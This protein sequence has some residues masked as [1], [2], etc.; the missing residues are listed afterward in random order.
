M[1]SDLLAALESY[2]KKNRQRRVWRKVV[3]ILACFVVFCTT[4]ALILPAI[5]QET[6]LH[7]G[8]DEHTHSRDCQVSITKQLTCTEAS[9]NIHVH[10]E[11]CLDETGKQICGL[12]DYV[13][14][15]HDASCLDETETL[16]C[17]LPE[18][19]GHLHTEACYSTEPAHQHTESCW[20]AEKGELTCSLEEEPEAH[21]HTEACYGETL[22]CTVAENHVHSDSCRQETPAC[23]Q[24]E[25]ETHTHTEQCSGV[26]LTLVCTVPE[27]HL[28]DESCYEAGLI[29]GEPDPHVHGDGC[30]AWEQVLT[31][32]QTG[33]DPVQ[34]LSCTEPVVQ[35]HIHG[36]DCFTVSETA[37]TCDVPEHSHSLICHSDPTAD[38]ETEEVWKQSMAAV[39]LTGEWHRD[40][41]AIAQSQ[42]GYVESVKNYQ[43]CD[44]GIT[45]KGY[46]RYGQWYGDPY[47][48]WCVMFASFCLNYAHVEMPLACNTVHWAHTLSDERWEL[49]HKRADHV[50]QPGEVIFFD[51]DGDE[52]P[53]HVGIVAEVT[54]E[55]GCVPQITAIEGNANNR[56]MYTYYSA[57]NED[58]LGYASL[59]VQLTAQ[60][61]RAVE[62]VITRI[63]ALP[64][65]EKIQKA[66]D[67]GSDSYEDLAQQVAEAYFY[68]SQLADYQKKLVTNWDKLLTMEPVWSQTEYIYY[69]RINSDPVT[70]VPSANT[71]DF[72]ELNIFDY[73]GK[74]SANTSNQKD[75]NERFNTVSREFPG[76]RWSGGAYPYQYS[77]TETGWVADR[78]LHQ[79]VDFGSGLIT[80][81]RLTA[82]LYEPGEEGF[83]TE[84]SVGPAAGDGGINRNVS[85][86][87][88]I[89]ATE[90][91]PVVSHRLGDDGYPYL[92]A[93]SEALKDWDLS[94]GYLFDGD[95][96]DQ[97]ARK[98]NGKN[99][100]GLF[101]QDPVSGEYFYNSRWNH[102]QYNAEASAFTLYSQT[103]TPNF[104][105]YPYGSFLPFQDIT[106]AQSVTQVQAF[107][108]AGGIEDYFQ[109]I[110]DNLAVHN[111][112]AQ[113]EDLSVIQLI[114]MLESYRNSW[115]QSGDSV[116]WDQLTAADVLEDFQGISWAD[117]PELAEALKELY[118]IDYDAEKNFFFGMEMKLTFLQAENGL[119]GADRGS[120]ATGTW[121]WHSDKN[122]DTLTAHDDSLILTGQSDGIP[123]YPMV[124]SFTG[125]DDVWVYIDGIRF[126]DLSGIHQ[127]V[128]GKIDFEKGMVYYYQ[129]DPAGNGTVKEE[130][131]AQQSFREILTLYGGIGEEDLGT[132]LKQDASGNYTTF[133]D[134]SVHNLNLYYLERSADSS[135]YDLRFNL[136]L[137]RNRSITVTKEDASV[138]GETAEGT[139]LGNPDYYFNI[140]SSSNALFV[141]PGSVTGITQYRIQDRNGN[142]LKNEDGTD[143]YFTTDA[144]GIFTLKAGQTAIFEGIDPDH[145]EFFVQELIRAEDNGQYAAVYSNDRQTRDNAQIDWSSRSYFGLEDRSTPVYEGPYGY[146]WYGRSGQTTESS[147]ANAFAFKQH[148]Q[149]DAGKLGSL[150]ISQKLIGAETQ[151][152][153]RVEV[154]LD[155]EKLP[156]GTGYTVN[157]ETRTVE[158]AGILSLS[159]GET[160][161]VGNIL[162][163]TQFTVREVETQPYTVS[164]AYTGD[165]TGDGGLTQ[166]D[167]V[168]GVVRAESNPAI[169]V[170]SA[171]DGALVQIP[172]TSAP[173]N[174]DGQTYSYTFLLEQVTDSTGTTLVE[175]GTLL[176][177]MLEVGDDPAFFQ[178]SIPYLRTQF[179]ALP[180]TFYYRILVKN[181]ENHS[182]DNSQ[183]FVAQVLVEETEDG[184]A[185]TLLSINGEPE[186]RSA[187]FVNTLAGSLT[188]HIAVGGDEEH[189]AKTFDFELG[190]MLPENM[191]LPGELAAVRT[192]ADGTQTLLTLQP[193]NGKIKIE[194]LADGET[195]VITGI[196]TGT[197]WNLSESYVNG[198]IVTTQVGDVT[199]E[200]R[201]AAGTTVTGDTAVTYI[202]TQTYTLPATGGTGTS[203][204]TMAG[205]MLMLCSA[206]YLLYQF[207]KHRKGARA[208]P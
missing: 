203:L 135:A 15:V 148:S 102:A 2:T 165:E 13:V 194:D 152:A 3:Q 80:D 112:A 198:F 30:Y 116:S 97:Y 63:E 44:D 170:T 119:T 139:L 189:K 120:N 208:N 124:F 123:D 183:Q 17:T 125:E 85:G 204:Y 197:Q 100:D 60:E 122:G 99:V 19:T 176:E 27:G 113:G 65:L 66:K 174:G 169:T 144:Y 132:Y 181:G 45:Q 104:I 205:W 202:N 190:L 70:V 53:N 191:E 28:H 52:V 24:S 50:P 158:E 117:H 34:V 157:G 126:L 196:P 153:F 206:A 36:E 12:V 49:F 147:F 79:C 177:Q 166:N 154:T 78:H 178:F 175:N 69:Y 155:G 64:T 42:L 145:G 39:E 171:E 96:P 83:Q 160:A 5:T 121:Q 115:Q 133:L 72:V 149:V 41:V 137:V 201:Y 18:R 185:A 164:Y 207:T 103:V 184:M 88:P 68:Y 173:A 58:I 180:A 168:T 110:L 98:K 134:Y 16:V 156:V 167:S 162:S 111:T 151:R 8:F 108:Y 159:S 136:P 118:N 114:R 10:S 95:H 101:R 150:T 127:T 62:M 186:L 182:L 179:D 89:G 187:D 188:L 138:A 75:I 192:G 71:G 107:N 14:H 143:R 130:P 74:Y 105:R 55:E 46:T 163:G 172:V 67:D 76:F 48:D 54:G 82:P 4:Y 23:T 91:T 195:V 25:D 29:C 131:F 40:V 6:Q 129:L 84:Q 106:D 77:T 161:T 20:T 109:T 94:L 128:G 26:I 11:Q 200:G 142:T 22:C 193:E 32:E 37:I 7:C 141:G 57:D 51:W 35:E 38:V 93:S 81:Y 199:G 73:A 21:T 86:E 140:V 31:C 9:L 1:Q 59:P 92:T 61:K 146:R 47:G 33:T 90:G 56:V 43:V 87:R